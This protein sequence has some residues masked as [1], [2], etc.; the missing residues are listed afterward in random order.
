[1]SLNLHS[2]VRGVITVNK[3]DSP[4]TV[5]RS[6]GQQNVGGIMTALYIK[7]EG[8]TGQW[9]SE[10]D[11]ALYH[12]DLGTQSTITRKVYL[13]APKDKSS[14]VW[15]VYRLNSRSGDYLQDDE[16]NYWLVTAVLED[17]SDVGW[18][19]LRVTLQQTAPKITIKETE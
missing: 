6:V 12:A 8:Y 10:G 5:Y 18:E 1:M 7:I 9:Q 13:Y 16:G 17:F 11:S 15:S 4:F 3:A 19:S 2:L 14:R